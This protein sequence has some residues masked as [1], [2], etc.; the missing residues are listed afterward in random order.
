MHKH[1]AGLLIPI[2]QKANHYGA[3]PVQFPSRVVVAFERGLLERCTVMLRNRCERLSPDTQVGGAPIYIAT[4]FYNIAFDDVKAL[5]E[6]AGMAMELFGLDEITVLRDVATAAEK[7]NK[8]DAQNI[9]EGL[10]D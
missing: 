5:G 4:M 2:Y 3:T 8:E 9:A 1:V 7:L 6:I 10:D